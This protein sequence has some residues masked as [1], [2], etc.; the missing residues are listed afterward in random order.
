MSDDL[1]FVR[2]ASA[3]RFA[4]L[5]WD[6]AAFGRR[7]YEVTIDAAAPDLVPGEVA[8]FMR[9]A[10]MQTV[11]CRLPGRDRTHLALIRGAGFHEV[12]LQ[13]ELAVRLGAR[14]PAE[15]GTLLRSLTPAD[16][17]AIEA[18]TRHA[19]L[20]TRFHDIPGV[21]D[22]QIGDRFV[23]WLAEIMHAAPDLALV[24]EVDGAVQGLF[25][26]KPTGERGE[27]YL[28]LAATAPEAPLGFGTYLYRAALEAYAQS[29]WRRGMTAIDAANVG[30][31]SLW[32]GLGARVLRARDIYFWHAER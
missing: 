20:A 3:L 4:L 14:G 19:F 11:T 17:P 26:S 27:L 18:I 22:A 8:R 25:A 9:E 16:R 5:P 12:E 1:R 29:G 23:R 13:L 30:V 10:G 28:A 24:L 15:P 31:L 2:G 6:V 21:T 32:M 7:C